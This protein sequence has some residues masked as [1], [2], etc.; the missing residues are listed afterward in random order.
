M[1]EAIPPRTLRDT[2]QRPPHG[3]LTWLPLRSLS[4]CLLPLEILQGVGP[5]IFNDDLAGET[6]QG[7]DP[8]AKML[9][10]TPKSP[11]ELLTGPYLSNPARARKPVVTEP[12]EEVEAAV[13]MP[14]SGGLLLVIW[15]PL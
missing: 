3:L 10:D 8:H 7:S 4:R 1:W 13:V 12:V 11:A 6:H 15:V 5:Q 9:G 14:A 2:V